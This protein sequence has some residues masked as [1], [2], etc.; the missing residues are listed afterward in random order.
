LI[1]ALCGLFVAG[2]VPSVY[3]QA[4]LIQNGNFTQTN[5]TGLSGST[6]FITNGGQ[7]AYNINANNWTNTISNSTIGYTFLFTPAS[8]TNNSNG[9]TGNGGALNLWSSNNGG[10]N[11]IT[12][13]PTNAYYPTA[14]NIIASDGAYETAALT[15]TLTNL[16][17]YQQYL[18]TFYWGAAQQT[19]YTGTNSSGWTV[20]LGGTSQSTAYQSNASMGFSGWQQSQFRYT[21][22]NTTETLSFLALGLP[23]GVPP[24]ALLG[25]VSLTAVPEASTVITGLLL[26]S[27]ICGGVVFN[28][29]RK[30]RS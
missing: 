3:S 2:L 8:F 16:V 27:V 15:Q 7:L 28:S 9:V 20:S 10:L 21:A 26:L 17:K 5:N 24:F 12:A 6:T 18:L 1:A 25:N 19:K 29:Q 22:T 4:N 13:P 11:A 30:K 14:G 23:S